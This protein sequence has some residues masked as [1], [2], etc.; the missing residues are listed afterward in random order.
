MDEAIKELSKR[1]LQ[2]F[3]FGLLETGCEMMRDDFNLLPASSRRP[4]F[5]FNFSAGFVEFQHVPTGHR[6]SLKLTHTHTHT[7]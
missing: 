3:F 2:L 5:F 1:T 6:T 4:H 7:N